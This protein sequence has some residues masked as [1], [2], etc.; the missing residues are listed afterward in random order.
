MKLLTWT[1]DFETETNHRTVQTSSS[2]DCL[3]TLNP[4]NTRTISELFL[5]EIFD[6]TRNI[7]YIGRLT[8][9]VLILVFPFF[10]PVFFTFNPSFLFFL[11]PVLAPFFFYSAFLLFLSLL[12]HVFLSLVPIIMLPVLLFLAVS[13]SLLFLPCLLLISCIHTTSVSLHL[14]LHHCVLSLLQPLSTF[15]WTTLS[16]AQY[17]CEEFADSFVTSARW[18]RWATAL[19]ISAD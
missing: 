9:A 5:A 13:P 10:F 3:P 12:L 1:L 6:L 2:P 19:A 8:I 11:L 4:C 14:Y 18:N 15:A 16:L 7:I 17:T